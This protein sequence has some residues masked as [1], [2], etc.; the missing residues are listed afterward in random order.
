[1]PQRSRVRRQVT[2]ESPERTKQ[3]RRKSPFPRPKTQEQQ[4]E[5]LPREINTNTIVVQDQ[6][7]VE[8]LVIQNPTLPVITENE[9]VETAQVA[10]EVPVVVPQIT[11]QSATTSGTQSPNEQIQVNDEETTPPPPT[12]PPPT[13]VTENTIMTN[14]ITDNPI[15]A[16]RY[17]RAQPKITQR[18]QHQSDS[19]KDVKNKS[20]PKAKSVT[21][22]KEPRENVRNMEQN[23]QPRGHPLAQTSNQ[24]IAM[25]KRAQALNDFNLRPREYTRNETSPGSWQR[26]QPYRPTHFRS[27]RD[28]QKNNINETMEGAREKM[29]R[30]YREFRPTKS[31]IDQRPKKTARRRLQVPTTDRI[32]RSTRTHENQNTQAESSSP[33]QK[34]ALER[35]NSQPPPASRREDV[36]NRLQLNRGLNPDVTPVTASSGDLYKWT[37]Q[38]SLEKLPV[39]T[40][41]V[42]TRK[43]QAP[44]HHEDYQKTPQKPK[45][46]K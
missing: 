45:P 11:I 6:T 40:L 25:Q 17:E 13:P 20:S 32:M 14:S 22:P 39:T 35:S 28:L 46:W 43:K 1:M 21:P 9:N 8:T 19:D 15:V 16:K 7:C 38:T 10:A 24:N 23:I 33:N 37:R 3:I 42:S 27:E 12:P 41:R 5:E 2:R 4:T 18:P 29:C 36:G 44:K 31:E 30:W 26:N 34:T